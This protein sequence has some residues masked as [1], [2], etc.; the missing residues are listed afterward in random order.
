MTF[1]FIISA[2]AAIVT[3]LLVV[4]LTAKRKD[5]VSSIIS[6]VDFNL[7]RTCDCI[8]FNEFRP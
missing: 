6:L 1:V 8:L 2:V 3:A 4:P 7:Y 5:M